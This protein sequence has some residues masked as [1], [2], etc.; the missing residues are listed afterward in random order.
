MAALTITDLNNGKVDLDFVAAIA[1][2]TD[3]TAT[4]RLGRSKLTMKGAIDRIKSFNPRGPRVTGRQYSLKDL[5]TEAGTVYVAVVESFNSVSTAADLAAGYISIHQGVTVDYLHNLEIT[6]RHI[7]LDNYDTLRAAIA[8]LTLTGGVINVP[9]KDFPPEVWDFNTRYMATP[10]ITLRGVKMPMLSKNCDRLVGG[11]IIQGRFNV[12]AD[13]FGIE[14]IGFDSGKYVVDKYFGGLDTHSADHPNGYTW[15]AFAFAQPDQTNPLPQRRGFYARNVIALNRDSQSF[16]HA[17]LMEGFDGGWVDNVTGVGSIHA[18]VIKASNVTV[19]NIYGYGAS[20]DH[21]IIKSDRYAPCRNVSVATIKTDKVPPNTAPWFAPAN[22]QYGLLL[23]PATDNMN[24]IKIGLADLRGA[25][26]PLCASGPTYLNT[27]GHVDG[28]PIYIL[29]DFKIEGGVIEG[30]GMSNVLGMLFN[31]LIFYR[32][33]I[34]T[35]LVNNVA[36]GISY[37]QTANGFSASPLKIG[38]LRFGGTVTLRAIQALGFG[39][40][41]IDHLLVEGAIAGL[42]AIDPNARVNVGRESLP[43]SVATKFVNDPPALT[44][45][46]QQYPGNSDF[47]LVMHNYG[48]LMTGYLKPVGAGSGN[49]CSLP[50]YLR[51]AQPSRR[52]VGGENGLGKVSALWLNVDPS[53]GFLAIN[54]GVN[55]VGAE[56]ALSMDGIWWSFD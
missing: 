4:D 17:M 36:D 9:A 51:T 48:L 13:N 46:W 26:I 12:F 40:I 18:V 14:D 37:K 32:C 20:T 22:C 50:R 30:L 44:A 1:T 21:V 43:G 7:W 23:N 28:D 5:Y 15:D 39:R 49:V 34:D 10:N 35:L 53:Y 3:V 33:E 8:E 2:S 11:S 56:T 19:G 55:A 27:P 6:R 29:D 47:R 41:V 16:G 54:N 25:Q 31:N 42:Y 52:L 38:T 45:Q 24:N